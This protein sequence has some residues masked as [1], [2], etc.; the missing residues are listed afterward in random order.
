MVMGPAGGW[1]GG[2]SSTQSN[3]NAGLPFAGVPDNLVGKVERVLRDEPEH[4]E[5][6]IA[7]SPV[8]YDRTPFTLRSC[9]SPERARLFAALALV[10]VE[11]VSRQA[12]PVL[13][14]IGIDRG[15]DAGDSGV[16]VIV[17]LA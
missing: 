9:L 10:L 6:D 13:T 15:L 16:L 5:P 14:Q 7:F 2:P 8:D 4:P 17:T 12:G 1:G 11:T 3:A